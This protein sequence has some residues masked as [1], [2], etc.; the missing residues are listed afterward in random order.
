M[1]DPSHF[2]SE[3]GRKYFPR[4]VEFQKISIWSSYISKC[5]ISRFSGRGKMAPRVDTELPGKRFNENEKTDIARGRA[6][7]EF[8]AGFPGARAP[9]RRTRNRPFRISL[10]HSNVFSDF[11]SA[12]KSSAVAFHCRTPLRPTNQ[13]GHRGPQNH[14]NHGTTI[15][16][17]T[18]MTFLGPPA[19]VILNQ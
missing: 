8:L 12:Q 15:F 3:T 5:S 4:K 9:G 16:S 19:E 10:T 1:G 6:G 11:P 2:C 18:K 13:G 17:H 7:I 14:R